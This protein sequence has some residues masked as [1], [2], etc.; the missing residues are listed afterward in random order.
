MGLLPFLNNWYKKEL[1]FGDGTKLTIWGKTTLFLLLT[2]FPVPLCSASEAYF[3]SG[4]KLV[5]FG[6]NDKISNAKVSI[7]EPSPEEIKK[8]KA[9]VV[10]LVTDF[11]PDNI[12]IEWFVDDM[13]KKANDPSIQTD[14]NS[15]SSEGNKSFSISSRLRLDAQD[16]IWVK[17]I[18]CAVKHYIGASDVRE[19]NYTL[20]IKA[21]TCGVSKENRNSK[22]YL[23]LLHRSKN[24][25]H[26]SSKIDVPDPDL[27]KHL[28]WNIHLNT[29]LEN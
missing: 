15:I 14:L 2:K 26:G 8:G 4:T 13:V 20:H 23:Y 21:V 24:A 19:S 25:K 9:T 28:L 5:V 18:K 3:G 16:W 29:C 7:F 22:V 10:C 1:Y 12:E 6:K 11:Y 27:Q 17:T